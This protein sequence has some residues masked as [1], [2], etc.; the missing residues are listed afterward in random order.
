MRAKP[1]HISLLQPPPLSHQPG[2]PLLQLPLLVPQLA[3][4]SPSLPGSLQ[5]VVFRET[6]YCWL[7]AEVLHY[8]HNNI[9][10]LKHYTSQL[11][12][13]CHVIA[14]FHYVLSRYKATSLR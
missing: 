6:H 8:S 11:I 14:I 10:G 12:V 13:D 5:P 2:Y 4:P 7:L 1:G 3:S 9:G